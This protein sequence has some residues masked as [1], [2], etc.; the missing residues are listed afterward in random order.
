MKKRKFR[1]LS[2]LVVAAILAGCGK[3]VESSMVFS[4]SQFTEF[5]SI[6]TAEGKENY[7]AEGK[8]DTAKTGELV[9]VPFVKE[10]SHDECYLVVYVYFS[11]AAQFV[12]VDTISLLSQDGAMIYSNE[13][14]IDEIKITQLTDTFSKG[15]ISIGTF[16]KSENW[17]WDG[18]ILNLSFTCSVMDQNELINNSASYEVT[19]MRLRSILFPT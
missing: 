1:F 11:D 3:V 6:T 13:S 10:V 7:I 2:F 4:I 12:S 16:P 18:N 5:L 15:T 19:L 17:F 8:L 14:S 9:F